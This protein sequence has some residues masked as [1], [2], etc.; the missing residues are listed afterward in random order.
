MYHSSVDEQENRTAERGG[1]EEVS[2]PVEH[3]GAGSIRAQEHDRCDG[4]TVQIPLLEVP[5]E[6]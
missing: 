6:D 3:N 1:R 2:A 4:E 5:Q